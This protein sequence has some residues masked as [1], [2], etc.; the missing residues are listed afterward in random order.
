MRPSP[1][2]F[3]VRVCW[4]PASR[5]YVAGCLEIPPCVGASRDRGEA[6]ERAYEAVA[7][8]LAH[9]RKLGAGMPTPLR[10]SRG[11]RILV[12]AP[13]DLHA[14]LAERAAVEGVSLNHYVCELLA[15][16]VAAAMALAQIEPRITELLARIEAPARR[17]TRH[18]GLNDARHSGTQP[19]K[20]GKGD[21]NR[22]R[23]SSASK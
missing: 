7:Q 12:R 9:R 19:P 14:A 3:N 6:V 11:G 5:E 22:R 13:R 17:A 15:R 10:R 20:A 4:D 21:R 23:H 1:R 16:G 18:E 2:D 8:H